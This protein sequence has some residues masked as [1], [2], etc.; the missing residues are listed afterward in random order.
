MFF[1]PFHCRLQFLKSFILPH[2][3]YCASIFVYMAKCYIDKM[4]RLYNYCIFILLNIKLSFLSESEQFDVLKQYNLFPYK[5]RLLY[6]F[7]TFSYKILKQCLLV[8]IF[9][10]LIPKVYK[11]SLRSTTSLIYVIPICKTNLGQKRLSFFLPKFVNLILKHSYNLSFN[12][13]KKAILSNI[14]VYFEKFIL[15]L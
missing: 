11:R 4:A 1:L 13:F 12:D 15:L 9:T 14:V 6:R 10:K 2:F 3:D 7:S 8:N 5:Y